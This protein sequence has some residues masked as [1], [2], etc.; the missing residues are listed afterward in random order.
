MKSNDRP[1]TEP[2][3]QPRIAFYGDEFLG[4]LEA[5]E[6]LERGGLESYLFLQDPTT[7]TLQRFPQLEAFGIAGWSRQMSLR[8][9]ESNLPPSIRALK[10]SRAPFIHYQTNATLESSPHYGSIGR[11]LELGQEIL[12]TQTVPIVP[13]FPEAGSFCAFGNLFMRDEGKK[14]C[15]RVDRHPTLGTHPVTPMTEADIRVHLA[16]QT[17]RPIKL[18]DVNLLQSSSPEQSL[19][20]ILRTKPSGLLFDTIADWHMALIGS[21]IEGLGE[22]QWPL[23]TIGSTAI[24]RALVASWKS[25][26][27]AMSAAPLK[28]VDQLLVLTDSTI[29]AVQN[30]NQRAL[31]SGFAEIPILPENLID[32][33]TFPTARNQI[34]EQTLTALGSGSSVLLPVRSENNDL[35]SASKETMVRRLGFSTLDLQL[36]Q[37]RTLGPKLG[38]I[39]E[40]ILQRNPLPRI[41]IAGTETQRPIAVA[42]ELSTLRSTST[43]SPGVSVCVVASPE[44]HRGLEIVFT[45]GSQ[46]GINLWSNLLHGGRTPFQQKSQSGSLE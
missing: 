6:V 14:E 16:F 21:L 39:L 5:L 44:K 1:A 31:S 17:D 2:R 12:G 29:D 13:A 33:Q 35:P 4:S 26:T 34:V 23:F 32:D 3:P 8:E 28:P 45:D 9:M 15:Y 38:N 42:L 25:D 7:E 27:E 19:Q 18:F 30:K 41:V 20:T 22:N 37:G 36:R 46:G 40:Q 43:S 10:Q 11:A 24:E